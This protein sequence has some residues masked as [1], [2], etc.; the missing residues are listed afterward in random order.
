MPQQPIA[1]AELHVDVDACSRSVCVKEPADRW[2]SVEELAS[3][4]CAAPSPVISIR[5]F[6]AVPPNCWPGTR[7]VRS[8][9][10]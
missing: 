8:A 4:R 5:A 3:P 9:A 7:G 1:L 6:A 2:Q 10:E